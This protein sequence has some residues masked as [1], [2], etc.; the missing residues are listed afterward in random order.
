MGECVL[1]V[2]LA[3]VLSSLPSVHSGRLLAAVRVYA[4]G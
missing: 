3:Y 1:G 4:I 2:P